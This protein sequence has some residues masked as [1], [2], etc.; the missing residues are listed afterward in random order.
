MSEARIR[1]ERRTYNRCIVSPIRFVPYTPIG[2]KTFH[3][4]NANAPEGAFRYLAKSR[5]E[6]QPVEKAAVYVSLLLA[7]IPARLF[8]QSR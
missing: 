4:S 7:L 5:K 3:T 2:A 1:I 6:L 8:R